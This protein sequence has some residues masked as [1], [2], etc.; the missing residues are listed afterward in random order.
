MIRTKTEDDISLCRE[1]VIVL[2]VDIVMF[3]GGTFFEMERILGKVNLMVVAAAAAVRSVEFTDGCS[4]GK[5]TTHLFCL[6]V[7]WCGL[8]SEG[9]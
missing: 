2:R 1:G 3:H 6:G 8:G 7:I 9:V 4:R 5:E